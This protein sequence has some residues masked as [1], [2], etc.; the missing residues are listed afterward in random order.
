MIVAVVLLI[1]ASCTG[2]S[3]GTDA[4]GGANGG[5]GGHGGAGASGGGGADAGAGGP[6]GAVASGG[7]GAGGAAGGAAHNGAQGGSGG[8]GGLVASGG[9]GGSGGRQTFSCGAETCTAGESYCY[10]YTPGTAGQTGRSCQP[11]PAAR[12]SAPTSCACLCPAASSPA[13]GCT[14]AGI[15]AGNFCSCTETGG[16]VTINCAGV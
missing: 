16:V 4:G 11:T 12:T 9:S 10:S 5:D 1:S 3:G 7:A 14:P 6:G 8:S 15:G 2:S 13:V